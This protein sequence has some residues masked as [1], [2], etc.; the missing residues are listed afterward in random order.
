M[1]SEE[2]LSAGQASRPNVP[3]RNR[4]DINTDLN[5]F[6]ESQP[7]PPKE[8]YEYSRN[9]TEEAAQKAKIDLELQATLNTLEKALTMGKEEG[10]QKRRM[11]PS[12]ILRKAINKG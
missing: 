1:G 9:T 7:A 5:F 6:D 2:N 3:I 12:H 4:F 11:I 8:D 10:E